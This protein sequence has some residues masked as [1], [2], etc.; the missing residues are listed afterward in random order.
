MRVLA[1][2]A[3]LAVAGC[4]RS[5]APKRPVFVATT[6]STGTSMLPHFSSDEMVAL[7]LCGYD[8]L[9]TGDTAVFWSDLLGRYINH[10]LIRFDSSA[11]GWMAKGDNNAFIDGDI[12]KRWNFVGRTKKL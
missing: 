8:D 10:R 9:K 7:E 6:H 2:I 3:I 11:G 12:V 4:S 5:E 1:I